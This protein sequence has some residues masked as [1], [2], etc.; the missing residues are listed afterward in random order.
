MHIRW[1][2]AIS[3]FLSFYHVQS[4]GQSSIRAAEDIRC[5]GNVPSDFA[6]VTGTSASLTKWCKTYAGARCFRSLSHHGSTP[7]LIF[8]GQ[9]N[10]LFVNTF[11]EGGRFK[12]FCSV[13]CH[14]AGK[15]TLD[16]PV[17]PARHT[18]HGPGVDDAHVWHFDIPDQIGT[19]SRVTEAQKVHV[20]YE[21]LDEDDLQP[22][23]SKAPI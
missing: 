11:I 15:T 6:A 16:V 8:G 20:I 4:Q 12:Q 18:S 21:R 5:I 23:P 22:I 2:A 9:V 3:P 13:K 17:V 7:P 1:I 10:S 14:C 19:R